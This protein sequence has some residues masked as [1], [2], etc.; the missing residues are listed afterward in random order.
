MVPVAVIVSA[1]LCNL[2]SAEQGAG[3]NP[4]AKLSLGTRGTS[5]TFMKRLE[6]MSRDSF[7]HGLPALPPQLAVHNLAKYDAIWACQ[8]VPLYH[9]AAWQLLRRQHPNVLT[10]YYMSSD[11]TR[12]QTKGFFDY[13]YVNT[14]HPEWFVLKDVK[15]PQH[16]DP[17]DPD[18]R[19]RWTEKDP[20]GLNYNRFYLDVCNTD[21]Q[22]WAVQ[23][24]LAC[25]S[26][27]RRGMT[28][29]Y[30]GLGADNVNIGRRRLQN[31]SNR[32]PN[33]AYA[34]RF[35][36]WN[37]GFCRYLKTVKEALNKRGFI[38]VANH[39][40]DYGSDTDAGC[41]DSLLNCVDGVMTEQS[42]LYGGRPIYAGA[43]WLS[44]IQKHERILSK[45][46]IDWWVCYPPETQPEGHQVFLYYYCSW[47]LVKQPGRSFFYATRDIRGWSNPRT[48]WYSEYDLPIGE[49]R[50]ARYRKN[51][52]WV[53]EYTNALVVVN[54]TRKTQ[55]LRFD[56][57]IESSSQRSA[58]LLQMPPTSGRI[59]MPDV[60][61]TGGR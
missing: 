3:D 16:A 10:L 61:D 53:R 27:E 12:V 33:W 6:I 34:G 11:T 47:L 38:L 14:H 9:R 15:N 4:L 46:L 51:A 29:P 2:C 18:N 41:W 30:H 1:V 17:R 21:F 39:T 37:A 31:I 13:E 23:H 58:S 35:D 49:P 7:S 28:I 20:K 43:A 59:L 55:K 45:G 54:P 8:F 22:K 56:N 44:S 32:Y 24:I 26:G 57:W 36:D 42:L 52:C 60:A 48:P 5:T 40:L 25:V 19:I 50:S